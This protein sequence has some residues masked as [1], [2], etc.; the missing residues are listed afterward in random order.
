VSP[1]TG[2]LHKPRN[3]ATPA[4]G[5]KNVSPKP[6][7]DVNNTAYGEVSTSTTATV[8]DWRE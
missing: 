2:K 6:T 3:C 1:Q 5:K 4:T 7:F 8:S